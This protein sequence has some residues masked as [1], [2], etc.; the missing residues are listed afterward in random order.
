MNEFLNYAA[1]QLFPDK[2]KGKTKDLIQI[3]THFRFKNKEDA[4]WWNR[5]TKSW[6][7]IEQIHIL[8][9]NYIDIATPTYAWVSYDRQKPNLEFKVKSIKKHN[10]KD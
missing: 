4:T 3:P 5:T 7:K 10:G 8:N 6:E 2:K 1:N 9:D